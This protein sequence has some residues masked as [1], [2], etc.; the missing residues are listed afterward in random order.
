MKNYKMKYD[1]I[2]KQT[3]LNLSRAMLNISKEI[4]L[5][6]SANNAELIVK[7]QKQVKMKGTTPTF[8]S[9]LSERYK[10]DNFIKGEGNKLAYT[11][12]KNISEDPYSNSPNPFFIYGG[13]GFGKTHL[14]QAIGNEMLNNN[15]LNKIVYITAEQ[16]TIDFIDAIQNGTSSDFSSFYKNLD[17]LIIDDI[18]FLND[19]PKTQEY[20]LHIFNHLNQNDKTIILSSDNPPL[21][22]EGISERL[23]SRFQ[24]GL[25]VKISEPDFD[26]RLE[27]LKN[28][29]DNYGAK[30]PDEVL[31]FIANTITS[32]IRE[33]EGCIFN[34]IS[35]AS[36]DKDE[37]TLELV[38]VVLN[39]METKREILST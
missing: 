27:I 10:F 25:K 35:R 16:F 11:S 13:V 21:K 19:K 24:S 37:I 6:E 36:L 17:V 8:I 38:K 2:L 9:N 26:T 14:I 3:K 34:L 31:K 23:I 29:A 4:I 7:G 32:S 20:F 12:A 18:Q 15:P 22:L 28:I 5:I 39:E 30:I 1:L 33:L